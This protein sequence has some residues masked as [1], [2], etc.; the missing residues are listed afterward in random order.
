MSS[1]IADGSCWEHLV[2]RNSGTSSPAPQAHGKGGA[3][4]GQ[5]WGQMETQAW[6]L[7]PKPFPLCQEAG[8]KRALTC[9]LLNEVTVMGKEG[10]PAPLEG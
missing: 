3:P 5:G 9:H 7:C 6:T 10:W 2:R 1:G 4:E 8:E